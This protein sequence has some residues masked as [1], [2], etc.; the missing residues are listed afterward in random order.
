MATFDFYLRMQ[1]LKMLCVLTLIPMTYFFTYYVMPFHMI[2]LTSLLIAQLAIFELSWKF[3][4]KIKTEIRTYLVVDSI[5]GTVHIILPTLNIFILGRRPDLFIYHIIVCGC[6][7]VVHLSE[8]ARIYKHFTL[9]RELIVFDLFILNALEMNAN[10]ALFT[11]NDDY[12][13]VS[14]LLTQAYSLISGTFSFKF[15]TASTS[16]HGDPLGTRV[17]KNN[18]DADMNYRT[19]SDSDI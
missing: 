18:G 9:R 13:V 7:H 19:S 15:K 1:A 10:I 4:S 17:S 12:F 8:L 14:L 11:Q 2:Y 16:S 5:V 3:P 6:L